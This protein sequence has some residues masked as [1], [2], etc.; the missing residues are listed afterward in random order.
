MIRKKGALICFV[1]IDGSGKTTICHEIIRKLNKKNIRVK[2]AWGGYELCILRPIV[3]ILKKT[4]IKKKNSNNNYISYIS[5]IRKLNK[6][7]I[8]LYPYLFFT[9]ME[10]FI[11]IIFKIYIPLMRGYNIISDRYLFDFA[12]NIK[13]NCDINQQRARNILKILFKFLPF[14]DRIFLVDVPE[15]IA[16]QRKNDTP[17]LE[18]LIL[19]KE[20]YK[21]ILKDYNPV[22]IDGTDQ[23]EKIIDIVELNIINIINMH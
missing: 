1:G 6:K 22:H 19:R 9:L 13:I 3:L 4:Y 16:F 17:S 11:Q 5:T 21:T 14:P 15:N 2:Y 8:L 7:I 12:I 18:Y 20:L 23:I 10:Y